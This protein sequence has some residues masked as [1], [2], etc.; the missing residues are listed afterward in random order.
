MGTI[1]Q[2]RG[3]GKDLD[4]Y[5]GMV[6]GRFEAK[7]KGRIGPGKEDDKSMRVLNRVV[8]WAEEGIDY[9]ADQR[10]AELIIQETGTEG[11]QQEC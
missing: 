3:K 8:H 4:W 9:E 6:L 2:P 5:G 7:V 10:H 11:R 1:S